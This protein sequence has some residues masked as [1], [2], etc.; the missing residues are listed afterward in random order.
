M[1]IILIQDVEDLGKK[2]EVKEVADGYARNFLIPNNLAKIATKE[3]ME[4][5]ETQK[6][7]LEKKVEEELKKLQAIATKIDG[8][9]LLIPVKIGDKGQLFEKI[10]ASKITEKLEEN[11]F[12]LKKDQIVLENPI[13]ETGEYPIKVKFDHSLEA[14]IK[15][16]VSEEE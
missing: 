13:E 2:H 7:I 5:L 8:F 4:W 6:E 14:E 12:Q 11:G 15:V 10:T 16:V 9:E 1:K 3:A